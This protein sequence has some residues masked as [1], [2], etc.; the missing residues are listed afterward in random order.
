[1]ARIAV[2]GFQHETNTFAS[3]P[4]TLADFQAPDAWPGLVRGAELFDAVQGINLPAAGFIDEARAGGSH[5]IPLAWCAAQPS[6][7][8]TR[9]AFESICQMLLEDLTVASSLDA[10]YLDLHGAMVAEH[11]D[12]ADGEL[13]ARVRRLV[14]P[15]VRIV[16]SLDFHANVSP[17]MVE[18]ADALVG[19]RT[20]PHV[21]MADTGAR[22]FVLLREV[23]QRP[24]PARL[25]RALPFL[26]PLTSQCT[27]LEPM[28]SLME[29]VQEPNPAGVASL[30]FFPGFPAADVAEC[31][32]S[33]VA[34][35]HDPRAVERAVGSLHAAVL[36]Q[37]A[38]FGLEL[39]GVEEAVDLARQHDRRPGHPLI[40]ADTQDNPGA[41]GNAD[42]TALLKAL[43]AADIP[44]MLAGV[45][46]DPEAAARAH[47]AGEGAWVDLALGARSAFPG[48]TPL[49]ARYRVERLGDGKFTGTGP[50]YRGGRFELGPMALLS[51]GGARIVVATRKQQAADQAMFRH[52]GAEPA[53]A[54]VLML[55]SSVHFRADFGPMA[56][57]VVLV[58]APGPNPADPA[59]LP[60]T[61]LPPGM[62]LRP[63]ATRLR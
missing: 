42:T 55:K 33:V 51:L 53:Q 15:D 47:A 5:L 17:R 27:L 40:L 36:G 32:P 49:V 19:Y 54:T 1:M 59:R 2:G 57:R 61:R 48:E 45:L 25:R 38:A 20:Y 12:D 56:G 16:A 46:W 62:R 44:G 13:L 23:L 14:G 31:G 60:F 34:F 7:R 24:C 41:G 39:A 8:V 4:A 30:G 37:E 11:V 50:F 58:E 21:D 63:G 52:V 22:A 29:Q 35:G 3:L 18:I 26:I 9:E 10:V 43:V 28:R 6:G